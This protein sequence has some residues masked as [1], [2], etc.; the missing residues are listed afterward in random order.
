MTQ[1]SILNYG[2]G[3]IYNLEFKNKPMKLAEIW[4]ASKSESRILNYS[5]SYDLKIE[6]PLFISYES[7]DRP[8][9]QHWM[10]ILPLIFMQYLIDSKINSYVFLRLKNESIFFGYLIPG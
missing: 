10:Q 2:W 9:I 5:N 1:K 4:P 8:Y 7:Y 3:S 6:G